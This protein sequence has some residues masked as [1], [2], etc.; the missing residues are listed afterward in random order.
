MA[1]ATQKTSYS[2]FETGLK[3]Q[4]Q[5]SYLILG[6]ETLL[7][8]QALQA[9]V[10]ETVAEGFSEYNTTIFHGPDI[11]LNEVV[12]AAQSAERLEGVQQRRFCLNQ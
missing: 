11:N 8:E 12:T 9:V 3:K 6:E 1:R 10:E 2:A 5:P 7:R 4:L